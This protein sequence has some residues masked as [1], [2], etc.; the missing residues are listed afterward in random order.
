VNDFW[1]T[2]VMQDFTE[3][4]FKQAYDL[5]YHHALVLENL[6]RLINPPQIFIHFN[7]IPSTT[8]Y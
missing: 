7:I 4:L 3:I 1:L 2:Y 8:F 5:Y 6:N